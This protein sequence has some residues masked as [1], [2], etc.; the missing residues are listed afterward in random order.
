MRQRASSYFADLIFCPLLASGLS[1][2]ALARLTLGGVIEWF[3]MVAA[4]AALW[5][6]IEYVMHRTVYHRIPLFERYHEVHHADPRAYVGAPPMLGTSIV[7]LVSFLPLAAFSPVLASAI[8]V[9]MLAGYSVYMIV[10][11]ACH[12]WTPASR[13]YL[14]RVRL[15]HAVHHFRDGNGNFGVSTSFWDDVFGT[16]IQPSPVRRVIAPTS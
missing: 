8:S 10:H 4:G 15:H 5:T 12:F 9:G 11:H 14:R 3:L 1:V 13:G 16:R 6:L 2:F 7:F